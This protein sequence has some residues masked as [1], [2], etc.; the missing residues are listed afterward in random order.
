MIGWC[1]K[2]TLT[3]KQEEGLRIAVERWRN[4]EKYTVIGGFAGA[5]KSTLIKFIIAAM[6]LSDEEVRYA[7]YTG[8]HASRRT[9][10]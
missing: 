3:R 7:A 4:G 9:R 5:G 2:L 1:E 6:G 8:C 10:R